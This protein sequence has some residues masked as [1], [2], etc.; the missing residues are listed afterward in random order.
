MDGKAFAGIW[1][2][3]LVGAAILAALAGWYGLT[4]TII[5]SM[6][7]TAVLT[8]LAGQMSEEIAEALPFLSGFVGTMAAVI[9]WLLRIDTW[10]H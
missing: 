8:G 6:I 1:N 7:V 4:A 2:A 10:L 9:Y 5:G 3:L